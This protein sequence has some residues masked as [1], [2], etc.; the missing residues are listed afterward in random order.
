MSEQIYEHHLTLKQDKLCPFKIK[1]SNNLRDSVCNW[2]TNIEILLV[3]GGEGHMQYNS[4]DL[5]ISKHDIIV[6]NSGDLHRVYSERGI[7][8]DYIIIDEGFCRDNGIN[9]GDRCFDRIFKCE[10]TER[11]C[12]CLHELYKDYKAS[13]SPINTAKLRHAVLNLIIEL[14]SEHSN[15]VTDASATQKSPQDYVKKVL[16]YLAEHYVEPLSLEG[17]ASVCGITKYHLA[18]EFKRYTGQTVITYINILRCKKAEACLTSGMTVTEAAC[19]SGFDSISYFSRTYKKLM[20]ASPS[21]IKR[22]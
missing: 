8:F 4:D 12:L 14:Y 19:E 18:R 1:T 20:G 16:E 13:P 21:S 3:T 15:S 5:P 17:V 11:K 10:A 6:I 9:T 2:H 7:S 22:I